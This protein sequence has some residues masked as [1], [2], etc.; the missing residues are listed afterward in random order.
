MRSVFEWLGV[1]IYIYE[2][3]YAYMCAC[4]HAFLHAQIHT[5]IVYVKSMYA[6]MYFYTDAYMYT[7]G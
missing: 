5:C 3:M 7:L 1:E 4:T 6:C 2:P